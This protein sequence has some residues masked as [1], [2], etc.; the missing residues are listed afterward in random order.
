MKRKLFWRIFTCAVVACAACFALTLLGAYEHFT[1]HNRQQLEE[2]TAYLGAA[3]ENFGADFLEKV[4]ISHHQRITWM[5]Q[6]GTV[7]YD[8]VVDAAAMENHSQREEVQQALEQGYGWSVRYSDT[9]DTQTTN[10]ALQLA[11]G[12]ILRLS[13][14]E[15]TTLNLIWGM[16]PS[17]VAAI[18]LA[19]LLSAVLAFGVS[20]SLLRPLNDIDLDEP[21]EKQVY[22]ELRPLVQR[23]N[24]QNQE[25]QR[26]VE[27]LV[28]EH[29][30]QD[31]LRREFTANVSHELK[32]PLT[33][34][35][36]Y[37]EII[38]EGI[39]R[40]EDV[41]RFASTIYDEARRLQNLVGDIIQ[42][43]QLEE[44]NG[45]FD[46]E[47]VDLY[48][49]CQSAISHNRPQAE[50]RD[51]M[52]EL[53]GDKQ[54]VMGNELLLTQMVSNL[55]DNA[56]KYNREGGSV[57]VVLERIGDQTVLTVRDTGIGIPEEDR[58]RVFERFYRVDK[59]HSK[60]IGGT[61]LGLSIVKHGAVCHNAAI[62]MESHLGEGTE[63]S[64]VFDDKEKSE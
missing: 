28:R 6:D 5:D 9:R 63:I 7:L 17:L 51:V 56:I 61:G 54:I 26:Q 21:D 29:E 49:V 46:K 50:R 37:A 25:L 57:A 1:D 34:I 11:D 47:L 19:V 48:A 22:P 24:S 10:Y 30:R 33:S 58:E 2:E 27:L 32:T 43:S 16:M 52:I 53:H 13:N 35:S 38:R 23:I 8:N 41:E 39:A 42:L 55:C 4:D 36:G 62:R 20:R 40:P 12:T 60:S 44:L 18:V 3:V 64:I 14:T 45:E 31:R 59:S 15:W